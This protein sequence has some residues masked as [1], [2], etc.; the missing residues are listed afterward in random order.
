MNC[1]SVNPRSIPNSLVPYPR[2]TRVFRSLHCTLFTW[3]QHTI[4]NKSP[5]KFEIRNLN[6]NFDWSSSAP[7]QSN[8]ARAQQ[9]FRPTKELSPLHV[10]LSCIL[11]SEAWDRS[12]NVIWQR[13]KVSHS[14]T[15]CIVQFVDRYATSHTHSFSLTILQ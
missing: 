3:V 14:S 10:Y 6:S 11:H 15:K 2:Y 8:Q 5:S 13:Q 1:L 12:S 9:L 4:L 7:R